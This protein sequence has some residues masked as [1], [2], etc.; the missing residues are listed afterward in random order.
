MEE[1]MDFSAEA[2]I[3]RRSAPEAA[4]ILK[5]SDSAAEKNAAMLLSES[6]PRIIIDSDNEIDA[7]GVGN[8]VAKKGAR[9]RGRFGIT[10]EALE[11]SIVT[12][13]RDCRV[14]ARSGSLIVAMEG[15]SVVAMA[16]SRVFAEKG[17][18]VFAHGDA[19]V[20][21]RSG[22]EVFSYPGASVMPFD[23]SL[24]HAT[25]R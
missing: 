17:A 21:A 1:S 20:F 7:T 13:E 10:I 22:S 9:V 16:N 3:A 4:E 5:C 18:N 8:I 12:A 19:S 15:S 23:G 24:V 25:A 14:V 2:V 11:G 6:G